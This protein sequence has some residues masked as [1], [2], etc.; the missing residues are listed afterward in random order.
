MC[1]ETIILTETETSYRKLNFP[2]PKPRLFFQD[3]IFDTETKFSKTNTETFFLRPFFS[4]PKPR[5]EKKIVYSWDRYRIPVYTGQDWYFNFFWSGRVPGLR[6]ALGNILLCLALSFL[7]PELDCFVTWVLKANYQQ[8]SEDFGVNGTTK[9]QT[10]QKKRN[11]RKNCV[12][13][14]SCQS[15]V[16]QQTKRKLFWWLARILVCVVLT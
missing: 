8:I 1:D 9:T 13:Y 6:Q 5:L 10:Q 7:L 15:Y 3:Q 2:K 16:S 14:V 4:K 11:C 12:P